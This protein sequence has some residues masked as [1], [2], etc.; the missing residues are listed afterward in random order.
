MGRKDDFKQ[1]NNIYVQNR[2]FLEKPFDFR[3]GFL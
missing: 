2:P 1:L 3:G